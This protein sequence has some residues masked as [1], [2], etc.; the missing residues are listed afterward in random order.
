MMVDQPGQSSGLCARYREVIVHFA[1]RVQSAA[2]TGVGAV[3]SGDFRVIHSNFLVW[4]TEQS[5]TS[6]RSQRIL[7]RFWVALP[8]VGSFGAS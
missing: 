3:V 8:G 2:V 7:Q 4:F 6:R 1:A 5:R